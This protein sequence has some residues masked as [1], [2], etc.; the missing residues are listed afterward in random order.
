MDHRSQFP[1]LLTYRYS[2]DIRVLRT[3]RE[4]TMGNSVTQLY[5]KLLEQHSQAW[6][7]RVLQYLTACEPFTKFSVV[8]PAAF[9]EP[10]LSP[11]LPKPKWLLAVYARDVLGGLHEV[12]AKITSI[13]GSVLKMDSTKKVTKKLAGAAAGAA[14]WCTNVGNEHGQVL[15]SVLTAGEGR[16]TGT[17]CNQ[18]LDEGRGLLALVLINFLHGEALEFSELHHQTAFVSS[19]PRFSLRFLLLSK[20][21]QFLGHL[22]DLRCVLQEQLFIL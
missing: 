12:E 7:Q 18:V 16:Y 6:T 2:C 22:S 15:V 19:F 5:K 10:P 21:L 1:A 11:V 14:A 4:R 17:R 13:I 8:R 9:A 20:L 3:M